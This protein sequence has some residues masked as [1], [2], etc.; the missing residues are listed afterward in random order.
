MHCLETIEK[1][2]REKAQEKARKEYAKKLSL[3]E[4]AGI[5]FRHIIFGLFR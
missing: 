2:N 5:L 4:K 1:L 3:I